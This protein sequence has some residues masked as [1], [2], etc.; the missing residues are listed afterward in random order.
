MPETIFVFGPNMA[1][2]S[3]Q[4][5]SLGTS[6]G[7]SRLRVRYLRPACAVIKILG[8]CRETRA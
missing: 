3:R 2:H 4:A 7:S 1:G 8:G 6:G 5:R